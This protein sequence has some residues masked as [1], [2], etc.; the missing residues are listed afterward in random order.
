MNRPLWTYRPLLCILGRHVTSRRRA[1]TSRRVGDL[2]ETVYRLLDECDR[3][4]CTY[5]VEV[6]TPADAT[7]TAD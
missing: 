4:G 1:A 7:A 3:P 6:E 5:V 2:H